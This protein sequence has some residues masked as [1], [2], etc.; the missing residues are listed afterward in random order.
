MI[1]ASNHKAL[2]IVPVI[3][4]Y[5]DPREDIQTKVIEF[6]NLSNETTETQVAY[7][8][9]ILNEYG[10]MDKVIAFAADNT[11]T[12]FGGVDRK[13]KNNI[14][15]RLQNKL[16]KNILGAGCG[17]HVLHNSIQTAADCLP[18]DVEVLLY[19]IYK[20]FDTYTVRTESLKEFCEFADVDYIYLLCH[21]KVRWISLLPALRR[22]FARLIGLKSYFLSIE[23]CPRILNYLFSNPTLLLWLNS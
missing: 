12:N 15:H 21:T 13:G 16:Q 3:V 2:K 6:T 20:Y 5:F 4:R 23:K 17:A 9:R 10:I 1:D 22:V 11:N 14:F 19:K 18:I 7:I 8:E